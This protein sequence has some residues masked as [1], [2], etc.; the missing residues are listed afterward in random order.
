[1]KK[2]VVS[3]VVAAALIASTFAVSTRSAIAAGYVDNTYYRFSYS[4]SAEKAIA[5]KLAG[6]WHVGEAA[7]L[8][9]RTA[10]G[11][12]GK[13]DPLVSGKKI[14]VFVHAAA[15][16]NAGG[17]TGLLNYAGA[18][19]GNSLY[20]SGGTKTTDLVLRGYATELAYQTTKLYFSSQMELEKIPYWNPNNKLLYNTEGGSWYR[21]NISFLMNA[22]AHYA[23]YSKL[24][25]NDAMLFGSPFGKLTGG[26]IANSVK[27]HY[28]SSS[29]AWT[30]AGDR[31]LPE[32][33]TQDGA[34]SSARWG[35]KQFWANLSVGYFLGDKLGMG[36]LD[37]K[38]TGWLLLNLKNAS[39]NETTQPL[40]PFETAFK[41][42]YNLSY[43]SFITKFKFDTAPG[44]LTR[45]YQDYWSF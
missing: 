33:L 9:A 5:Q 17:H 16:Y 22:Y 26:P 44:T 2:S 35:T 8:A 15:S 43:P 11:G 13:V 4:T 20:I 45:A 31:Y 23:A 1:M 32:S 12:A 6:L 41:N 42:T 29:A 14:Q 39:L 34:Q 18:A 19:G 10:V 27:T 30:A 38:Q 37:G 24:D 28:A 21:H 25:F 3:M 36:W 7:Q 40:R